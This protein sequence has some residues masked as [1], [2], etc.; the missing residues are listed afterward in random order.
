MQRTRALILILWRNKTTEIYA[1][2]WKIKIKTHTQKKGKEI[3]NPT[4]LK[5]QIKNLKPSHLVLRV[6]CT[7]VL[8]SSAS[9]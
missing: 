5:A 2:A 6:S 1:T 7:R 4:P 8:Q 9:T 3:E